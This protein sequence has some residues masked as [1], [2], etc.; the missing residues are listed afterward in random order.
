MSNAACGEGKM[1]V[2]LDRRR[3]VCS[4]C[5]RLFLG[6][7]WQGGDGESA[8]SPLL[9]GSAR[10]SKRSSQSNSGHPRH[11]AVVR[12]TRAT[13]SIAR[14]RLGCSSGRLHPRSARCA[15][16]SLQTL[17]FHGGPTGT[18]RRLV[19]LIDT[20]FRQG[21]PQP[22][23]RPRWPVRATGAHGLPNVGADAGIPVLRNPAGTHSTPKGSQGRSVR[24]TRAP[25]A[26]ER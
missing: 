11:Q 14:R 15:A 22:G 7:R 26:S 1:T 3:Q 8:G 23:F 2:G 13:R 21:T 20:L 9:G 10:R 4:V 24:R 17:A 18:C 19:E 12:G 25:Y 5:S 6:S 16:L